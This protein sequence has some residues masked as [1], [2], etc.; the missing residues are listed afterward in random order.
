MIKKLE[1]TLKPKSKQLADAEGRIKTSYE[2]G[3]SE[4]FGCS[5]WPMLHCRLVRRFESGYEARGDC[6][7]AVRDQQLRHACK[8]GM[9]AV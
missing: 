4:E 7:Y 6:R 2:R 3:V 5:H 9:A 1:E 8:S